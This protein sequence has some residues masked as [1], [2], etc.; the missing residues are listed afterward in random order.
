MR[1]AT[2]HFDRL[3]RIFCVPGFVHEKAVCVTA[4]SLKHFLRIRLLKHIAHPEPDRAPRLGSFSIDTVFRLILPATDLLFLKE[5]HLR[6]HLV[7]NR[8]NKARVSY[9]YRA[10]V[11]LDTKI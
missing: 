9:L 1:Q 6:F 8:V 4:S 11:S 3:I 10:P 2:D 7:C 5:S